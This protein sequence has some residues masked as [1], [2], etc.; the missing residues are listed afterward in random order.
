MSGVIKGAVIVAFENV[1]SEF[2][3]MENVIQSDVA[4]SEKILHDLENAFRFNEFDKAKEI[5]SSIGP[6]TNKAVLNQSVNEIVAR[7]IQQYIYKDETHFLSP[8]DGNEAV[9]L[10][11]ADIPGFLGMALKQKSIHVVSGLLRHYEGDKTPFVLKLINTME[12]ERPYEG[13][14]QELSESFRREHYNNSVLRI[15]EEHLGADFDFSSLHASIEQISETSRHSR[16]LAL[17]AEDK[18]AEAMEAK[19]IPFENPKP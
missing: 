10:D 7:N 2:I 1:Q 15:I 3:A 12:P 11:Q 9:K 16:R 4:P 14:K 18:I 5:L 17:I 19:I 13:N 8:F 6:E